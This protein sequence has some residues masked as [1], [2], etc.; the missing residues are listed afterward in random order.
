MSGS[1]AEHDE[2]REVEDPQTGQ[3]Y[4]MFNLPISVWPGPT[5]VVYECPTCRG[6]YP[7]PEWSHGC[8]GCYGDRKGKRRRKKR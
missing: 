1:D 5:Y 3:R 8:P 2:P 7:P 6:R 4:L